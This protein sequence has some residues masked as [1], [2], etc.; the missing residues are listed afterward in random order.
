MKPSSLRTWATLALRRDAGMSTAGRSMRLALRM[1]VN[2]S[3]NESVIMVV[4]ASPAGFLDAGDQPV[5]G[6]V[7][8]TDPADAKLTVDGAGAA[9]Q[10]A[11]QADADA[12]ARQHRLHL[13]GVALGVL[14]PLQ[15]L[16]KSDVFRFGR[17]E[18]LVH[19]F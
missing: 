6:H 18:A 17:H 16:A 2:M 15:L 13:A 10:L 4:A 5:A 11:A 12:L 1:R 8:K 3:A 14:Q 19:S 9:A 7:A